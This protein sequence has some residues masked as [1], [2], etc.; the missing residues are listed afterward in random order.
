MTGIR[1]GV[2]RE[3]PEQRPSPQATANC[4]WQHVS[5][6]MLNDYTV[7]PATSSK[8]WSP[9]YTP[10]HTEIT[11]HTASTQKNNMAT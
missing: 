4:D 3:A 10:D 9:D 2:L 6:E 11:R 1:S 8:D 7:L 5:S